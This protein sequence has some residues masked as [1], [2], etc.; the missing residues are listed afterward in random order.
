MP[1]DLYCIVD[2]SGSMDGEKIKNL[3]K[4]LRYI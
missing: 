2:V 4:S 3:K 1:I